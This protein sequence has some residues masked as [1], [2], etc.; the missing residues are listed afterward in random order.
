MF[1]KQILPLLWLFLPIYASTQ[2]TTGSISGT[3]TTNT[4]ELLS[5]AVIK[6][7]HE[8]TGTMYFAKA[9]K[10]GDFNIHNISPGG[11][12]LLEVS[13]VGYTTDKRNAIYINL[14]DALNM[15]IRLLPQ[16]VLLRSLTV[17]AKTKNS[18]LGK[19]GSET[20]ITKDKIDQL[21]ST[22]RNLYD[23]LRSVPQANLVNGNEG[24][25]SFA[26]QNNRYNAF[27]VDGA[28][29]NDVF[30][31]TASGTNG[32]QA[33]IA[34]LSIDAIEQFQVVLSPYDVS[35]GNFTG[36]SVNA[37]TRSGTNKTEGSVY[38]FFSNQH[39]S[40]GSVIN[41]LQNNFTTQ[42]SGMRLQGALMPHKVFY[43]MSMEIQ[44]NRYANPYDLTQYTGDTK[45]KSII[46][47][48]ANT[49]RSTYHYDAGS[50]LE[51]PESVNADRLVM[52][53]DWNVNQ[54]NKLSI[55]NRYTLAQ[56]INT[57]TGNTTTIHFS[58]DGFLLHTV[59]NSGSLEWRRV[60]GT[61]SSN[62]LITTY[63]SVTDDRGPAGKAFP[64]VRI[65]DGEGAIIF[66]TDNSSTI[67]LV[68]QKN[69]T[70]FDKYNLSAGKHNLSMGID[71]EYNIIYNAFIQNSFGNYTYA[72][73]SDFFTNQHPS[74]YRLG[75]SLVDEKND[76]HT[77]AAAKS[78][79]LKT[80][81]FINDEIKPANQISLHFGIR[82][83][84]YRF[85]TDPAKNDTLNLVYLPILAGYYD[86]QNTRSGK[87]PAIPISISPRFGFL[88]HNTDN[89]M[90]IR[91]GAGIF[92]GRIPLAWPGGMYQNN[93]IFIGGFSADQ[94][95]LN[96]IRFRSDAYQQ[97]NIAA[98]GSAVNQEPLNLMAE[99]F[100][101]PA[102]L[103]TSV[104]VEKKIN[105]NLSIAAEVMMSKNLNE[106]KYTNINL[107]PATD[108]LSG[109]DKRFIYPVVNEG[110]I[111]LDAQGANPYDYI[112]L[113]GNDR[114]QTGY[115]QSFNTTLT[116]RSQKGWNAELSY[117]YGRSAVINEGTSSINVSQ[118]RFMETVNGKNLLTR[119]ISDFSSGH[120]IFAWVNK[121]NVLGDK[122]TALG[123]SLTYTG[124][125]GSPFSY[126]YGNRSM[127]RDDGLFSTYDL[128]YIPTTEELLQM[129]FLSN[130]IHGNNYTPEQQKEALEKFLQK[131]PYLK[132]HRGNY[133][134]RNGSR[135]PFTQRVDLK[136]KLDCK[137]RMSKQF[138]ELQLSLDIFNVGN[139]INP[140][141]GFQYEVPFDQFALIDFAGYKMQG[142]YI[143]QYRFNPEWA[144]TGSQ[145]NINATSVPAYSSGWSSQIGIRLTFK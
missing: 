110:K 139:L 21:P 19:G 23:Y 14:G 70:L 136:L 49:L 24:A 127:T 123:I 17:S 37:I 109:P 98:T 73:L 69:L 126:V 117:T 77:A 90:I 22:G 106:I 95:Q 62:K 41:Q 57:N 32:G 64:K 75:F 115:A 112:I 103:R 74:A 40:G 28:V 140:N 104:S 51:A 129:E 31:L 10:K 96:K 85:L 58:N 113:L 116:R 143:P 45:D 67:N 124:Q 11:P 2:N 132:K 134:E 38:H 63:T 6:L 68:T 80:A 26:G 16:A 79:L 83:D 87:A 43:F 130:N 52:R 122:K 60:M 91:G 102:L 119:S 99:K 30:G 72:S 33:G 35:V 120:R 105:S 20:F 145:W 36:G 9:N 133:A 118:W 3:V 84:Q 78:S 47:I 5:G 39:L 15:D 131:D 12:Y 66:G 61:N 25:V 53:L 34:P 97:W 107:L 13:F 114:K 138:Y 93:G 100:D 48:L 65:N 86:L 92:T 44:R 101:M 8:P 142:N 42:T 121:Q 29:N 27:Y 111:P 128:I 59:T 82:A 125:S 94:Q 7:I 81:L 89:T 56:R 141:W 18:P 144:H 137:L 135:T 55:S 54:R 108:T 4:G 71:A 50:F 76:D 1:Y 88:Y 46:N